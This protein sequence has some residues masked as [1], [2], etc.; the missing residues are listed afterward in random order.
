MRVSEL[1]NAHGLFYIK[2]LHTY[3]DM[4]TDT[5]QLHLCTYK[6]CS[7]VFDMGVWCESRKKIACDRCAYTI[8]LLLLTWCL[9]ICNAIFFLFLSDIYFLVSFL[10][11]SWTFSLLYFLWF[12]IQN[13]KHCLALFNTK[14]NKNIYNVSAK[15]IGGE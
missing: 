1:K 15:Y 13:G 14:C 6:L 12:A 2:F 3:M 4:D 11:F 5:A 7:S 10:F 9:N 8:L